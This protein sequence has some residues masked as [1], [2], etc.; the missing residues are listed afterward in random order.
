MVT[1][2]KKM[3]AEGTSKPWH[4]EKIRSPIKERGLRISCNFV[5]ESFSRC[6]IYGT[7]GLVIIFEGYSIPVYNDVF[8]NEKL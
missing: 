8:R 7:G 6:I 3:P 1:V 5:A 4:A 2:Q